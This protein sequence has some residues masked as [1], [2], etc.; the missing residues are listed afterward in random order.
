MES[1]PPAAANPTYRWL[2]IG[3]YASY[4]LG[5]LMPGLWL[6]GIVL[7]FVFRSGDSGDPLAE[8]HLEYQVRLGG[9]LLLWGLAALAAVGLLAM[10]IVGAILGSIPFLAWIVWGIVISSKGLAAL[11][12]EREPES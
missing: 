5:T 6:I 7:A 3:I 1:L 10:T 8:A 11:I 2:A 9:R 4:M 12:G